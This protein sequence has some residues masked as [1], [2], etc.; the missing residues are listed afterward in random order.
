M[1]N[2]GGIY[3]IPLITFFFLRWRVLWLD[4]FGDLASIGNSR[5][6]FLFKHFFII[7]NK[8][9]PGSSR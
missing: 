2:F 7:R 8:Y 9:S 5:C 4:G 6:C 3:T 1:L